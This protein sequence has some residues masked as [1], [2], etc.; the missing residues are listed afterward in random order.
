MD[1]KRKIVRKRKRTTEKT[2]EKKKV[3]K[4]ASDRDPYLVYD[5]PP[6]SREELV[7]RFPKGLVGL[8]GERRNRA[9]E[10]KLN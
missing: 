10:T 2:K 3:G 6:S 5:D 1:E 4:Y 8:K 7:S 9:N